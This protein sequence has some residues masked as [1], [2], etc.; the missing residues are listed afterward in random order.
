M[1]L[2]SLPGSRELYYES[3]GS[4]SPLLLIQGMAG[5]HRMWTERFVAGLAA[6]H[7]VISYDHRGIGE[8]SAAPAEFAVAELADDAADLLAALGIERAH[9]LGISLGGMVAQELALRHADRVTTLTLGCTYAGG[10]GSTLEAPGPAA[11]TA[12]MRSGDAVAALRVSY[13][14]NLSAGYR[15]AAGEPG[16][17]RFCELCLS[18]RVP[19]PVVVQQARARLVHDASARLPAIAAPTLVLHGTADEM[20]RFSNGAQIARL[21][22]GARLLDFDAVGHLFWWER[23]EQSVAAVLSHCH[24]R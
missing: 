10:P 3:T 14:M 15:A 24:C 19:V 23:T 17:Q 13:E 1:P 11:M 2:A 6:Q 21:I 18:V 5:H 20:L 8:S 4:G 16:F 9:V 7:T 22:P 12:A